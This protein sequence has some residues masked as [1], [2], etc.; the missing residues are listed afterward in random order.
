MIRCGERST[1]EG[2]GFLR[3]PALWMMLFFV[4]VVGG[5]AALV[6]ALVRSNDRH[7]GPAITQQVPAGNPGWYAQP[8]GS[9]RYWD[10]RQW[11]ENTAP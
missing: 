3:E 6:V 10:G 11:T 1:L 8:D 4:I 5:V 7:S 2:M 9:Q